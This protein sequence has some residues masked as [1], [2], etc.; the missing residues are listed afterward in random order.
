MSLE[1]IKENIKLS[2]VAGEES[3]QTVVEN[4]IIVPDIKP[5]ISRILLFDGTS[6]VKSAETIQDKILINGII[7]YKILY[8]SDEAEQ[9]LKSMNSNVNFSYDLDVPNARHGMK[10]RVRCDVEHIDFNILNGRKINTKTIM[11]LSGKVIN[12]VEQDIVNDLQGVEDIQI[13]KESVNVNCFVG[14]SESEFTVRESL[15]VPAGKPAIRDIL[16]NDIRITGKDFKIA[17]N[18]IV[19]KGDLNVSTLYLGDDE[20]Q[21]IQFME[22]EFPFTHF[23]GLDG[24]SENDRCDICCHIADAKFEPQEDSDGELRILNAEILLNISV[25]GFTSRNIYIIADAYNPR[26]NLVLE[27]E[28]FLFEDMAAECKSQ[29]TLKDTIVIPEG[30]PDIAEVFNVISKP[31]LSDYK[32]IDDKLILEGEVDNNILYLA[33]NSEQ[34]VSGHRQEV[35][36]KQE[37]DIR[38]IK[39]G[40]SCDIDLGIEHCNYSMLSSNEVEIRLVVGVNARIFRR[41]TLPLIVKVNEFP[42][43]DKKLLAQPSITIYF[44]QPGDTL[45][46]VAK[47]YYTTMAEIQ[48]VNN[49]SSSDALSVGQQI[50]IPKR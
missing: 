47:K 39:P 12:N 33:D 42:L 24:M 11:R 45:W 48:R 17:D 41:Y 14:E 25:A 9:R 3:T 28:P 21:S 34:P 44:A 10:C 16:R 1:F 6:T 50:I 20:T 38:G 23:V 7:S 46:K 49:I 36:F 40:M 13:L 37:I 27:K 35:L 26:A 32:I 22:H 4:D 19:I 2:Q 15:E 43:D 5:D 30:N 18:R 29:I 8:L 31:T